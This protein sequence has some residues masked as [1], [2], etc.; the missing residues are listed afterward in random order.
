MKDIGKNIKQLRMDRTM[1]QD[2]LAEKLFITRQTVSNYE[3]GKS[4]P[5]VEMLTRIADALETDVNTLIYGPAPDA[6]KTEQSRLIVGAALTILF[7]LLYAILA[8]V[9][10]RI[11]VTTFDVG[12]W[13]IIE[14]ILLPLF[15]LFAGWTLMQMLSM[16]M[17]WKPLTANWALWASR[18]ITAVLAI[19]LIFTL[20]FSIAEIINQ[21]LYTN[22]IRGEWFEDINLVTGTLDK[23]WSRLPNPVP[24][25]VSQIASWTSFYIT[26]QYP[27]LYSLLGAVVWYLGI[28]K[29][30]EA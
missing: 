27:I 26:E 16:A 15:F 30:K 19:I 6:N 11:A 24:D 5:D 2:E 4:R 28:P 10:R 23:G 20:W 25:F 17:K 29:R 18:G 12:W 3:V 21:Y 8:P 1:T 22:H 9:T 14:M 7:G 13:W